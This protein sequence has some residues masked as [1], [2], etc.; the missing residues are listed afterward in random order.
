ML[1]WTILLFSIIVC[2]NVTAATNLT[3]L[4]DKGIDSWEPK[5]FSGESIYTIDEYKGRLA[6][7][8]LSHNAASGLVLEQQIDLTATPYL[9]W[10]WLVEKTLLQ[11]DERS[12]KG[13][14][15]VARI[16]VVIDGGFMVWKTKSLNYVWSSNQD[17]DLVWD[18]AFAGSSVK[19][20]SVRGKEAQ[21]G[22]WYQEK[23]NV[24]QDLI[25]IF[26]DK[27]SEQANQKAYKYIDIIAIMTDTDNSGKQA[28]SYYGDIVFSAM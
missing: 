6:L 20:M 21:K 10:S 2:L 24:Y 8:A 25:D 26:G 12:K 22:Q 15:F 28:E 17:K 13:D 1:R 3:S 18:N 19:M 14:D 11:L 5:E 23:R 4:S 27:G 16:Y 9:N 7:K